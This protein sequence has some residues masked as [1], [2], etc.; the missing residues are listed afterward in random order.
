MK[1]RRKVTSKAMQKVNIKR[2]K[3]IASNIKKVTPRQCIPHT[4]KNI[5]KAIQKLTIE[6]HKKI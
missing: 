1:Q 2:K 4:P 5:N 6:F 3:Y